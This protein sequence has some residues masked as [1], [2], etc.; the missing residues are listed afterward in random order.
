MRRS[1]IILTAIISIMLCIGMIGFGVY[2]NINQSY[3]ISN[4]IGF[5]P[6]SDV[7]VELV[8][9]VT[10]CKQT[11]ITVPPPGYSS[12][13]EYFEDKGFTKH[14]KFDEA[15][16]GT[17]QILPDWNILESLEFINYQ[18]PI[19]YSIT[20]YNYSDREI[21]V[22]FEDYDTT[23]PNYENTVPQPV[24]I[25]SY[26]ERGEGADPDSKTVVLQTKVK[27]AGG[28]FTGERND[29]KVALVAAED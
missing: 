25:A 29:F 15:T 1:M 5:N 22:S 7:Y 14:I 28:G 9:K 26:D 16:R 4:T 24:T 19:L 6:S 18:T 10:G 23:N 21:T 3:S 13:E 8:C 2:A 17:P 20:V 11:D 12:I 27:N